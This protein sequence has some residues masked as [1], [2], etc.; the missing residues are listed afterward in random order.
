MPHH[1]HRED[2][3]RRALAS[4]LGHCRPSRLA[5]GL[6]VWFVVSLGTTQA[7]ASEPEDVL[8]RRLAELWPSAT[9]ERIVPGPLPGWYQA[10]LDELIV[11]LGAGGRYLFAGGLFDL[12][13]KTNLTKTRLEERRQQRWR[14]ALAA[15]PP[16]WP[17]RFGGD[18][19]D[20]RQLI[21]FHDPDCPYCRRLHPELQRL[22]E[23]GW[24]IDVLLYPQARLHPEAPAK[25]ASV[26]CASSEDRLA[27]LHAAMRG[28]P[29]PG[30]AC[31]HPIDAIV[32]LG[33]RLGVSGTPTLVLGP[34]R[35]VVTGYRSAEEI[36]RLF[37]EQAAGPRPAT[38]SRPSRGAEP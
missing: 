34:Q 29:V 11:Y 14:E 36:E 31:A 27:M 28:E 20:G 4:L 25:A 6:A 38:A 7:L 2:A 10:E 21:V 13:T 24:R 12:E 30:R 9:I 35:Q 8:R 17:I 15:L 22:A 33:R 5:R 3:T 18:G 16:E 37:Q 1:N 26:W 19:A 23:R 32:A